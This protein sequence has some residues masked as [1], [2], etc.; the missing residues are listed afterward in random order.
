MDLGIDL[1]TTYTVVSAVD[2]GNHPLLTFLDTDGDPHDHVP[3]VSAIVDGEL[4]HGYRARQAMSHGAPG[5]RSVKRLLA[6]P[7]AGPS[8]TVTI[9]DTTLP[10]VDLWADFLRH[11][12]SQIEAPG[13]HRAVL[14]VP[15]HAHSGQRLVTMDAARR[16]GLGVIGLLNEPSAAGLEYALRQSRNLNSRRTRVIIYDLGGGTFDASLVDMAGTSAEVLDSVGLNDLGGD[17]FDEALADLA[18]GLTTVPREALLEPCRTAKEAL[19]PQSR[20]LLVDLEDDTLRIPVSE[21]TRVC[22]PLVDRSVET[23]SPLSDLLTA[24]GSDV[25][26]IHLVGGGTALPL[27]A[28]RL[29]ELFGRRVHRSE[30]PTGATAVGLAMAADPASEYSVRDRLSRGFGVFRELDTG[31]T[32][33]F[34]VLADQTTR[35]SGMT[36]ITRTYRTRHT[37]GVY[38]FVE[39]SR[40]DRT[41]QPMGDLVPFAT[42]VVPFVTELQG[43]SSVLTRPVEELDVRPVADGHLVEETYTISDT[44]VVTASITDLD[45]GWSTTTTMSQPTVSRGRP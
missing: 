26:A 33:G 39:F 21:V 3:S 5:V 10:L 1:G 41:G 45:T 27:V 44:G 25:A 36:T 8:T 37:I 29:R 40:T 15:A 28:R 18:A 6:Q 7:G 19:R 23:M 4:V 34:D 12:I 43:D 35:L 31:R 30:Q 9:G 13:P 11:V 38:R 22:Q 24:P 16:A 14:G 2:S 20:N 42:V 17:D 32:V